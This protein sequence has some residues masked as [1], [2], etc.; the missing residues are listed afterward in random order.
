MSEYIEQCLEYY[1]DDIERG[2]LAAYRGN[3]RRGVELDDIRQSTIE[4]LCTFFSNY[5]PDESK[6]EFG[7]FVRIVVGQFARKAIMEELENIECLYEVPV[8]IQ[9]CHV[10]DAD[11]LEEINMVIP[12]PED[13]FI[14]EMMMQGWPIAAIATAMGYSRKHVNTKWNKIKTILQCEL[15]AGQYE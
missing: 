3:K 8:H 4:K 14:I 15:F 1:K 10:E 12:H 11:F 7:N 6:G 2:I 5:F 13:L 9:K